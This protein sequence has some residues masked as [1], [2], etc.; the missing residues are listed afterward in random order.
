M[1]EDKL[2]GRKHELMIAVVEDYINDASPITSG[3]VQKNHL[4]SVSTATLRNE[5]SALEAMG[6]LKQLHTSGGRVPTVLGY[7][8]YV[9]HLLQG[10]TLNYDQLDGVKSL[11]DERSKSLFEIVSGVAKIIN[12][13]VKYPTVIYVNGYDKLVVENIKII[14]LV[15]DSALALIQTSSGYLTNTL[16]A[17]ASSE[18]YEDASKYLTKKFAG[19]TLG[20]M[21]HDMEKLENDMLEEISGFKEILDTLIEGIKKFVEENHINIRQ[22]KAIDVLDESA[23]DEQT[24][25]MMKLLGDQEE[26]ERALETSGGELSVEMVDDDEEY[27]GLAVIKAPLCI[28]GTP[29]ASIGVFGP[30][31]MDYKGI[32]SA[33]KVITSQLKGENDET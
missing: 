31:R 15:G 33:L 4:T 28:D 19:K 23:D 2:K 18:A 13:A 20:E 26:L 1:K 5:L 27:S 29:V 10:L 25:K 16:D 9:N 24:K 30:Q 14:P 32:A 21:M 7:K 17:K 12:R 8:Y 11:L 6:L 22:D 3:G